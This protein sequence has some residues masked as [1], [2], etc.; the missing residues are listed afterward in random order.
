MDKKSTHVTSKLV[1]VLCFVVA[2]HSSFA[3]ARR[4]SLIYSQ[5]TVGNRRP[6]QSGNLLK[7]PSFED[8]SDMSA[9]F[10]TKDF[11]RWYRSPQTYEGG[12]PDRIY[13]AGNAHA[14]EKCLAIS[15]TRAGMTRSCTQGVYLVKGARYHFSCWVKTA[16]TDVSGSIAIPAV[17][18][19]LYL[20]DMTTWTRVDEYFVAPRTGS[21]AIFLMG[22][23]LGTAFNGTGTV[24]FDDISIEPAE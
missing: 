5:G 10:W 22:H 19:H 21:E 24:Y 6:S 13:V 15:S 16:W 14:G 17:G 4:N 23:G 2:L 18:V 12:H 7:N 1:V 8:G 3:C 11:G 20:E 9:A